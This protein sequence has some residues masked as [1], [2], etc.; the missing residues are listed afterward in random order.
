[1]QKEMYLL[2][3]VMIQLLN[4]GI[5]GS[6]CF[7][8]FIVSSRNGQCIQTLSDGQDSISSVCMDDTC[9]ITGYVLM[10]HFKYIRSVDGSIRTYDIRAGQLHQDNIKSIISTIFH[11]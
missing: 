1:M 9:I 2:L 3:Q 11:D 8:C 10:I 6:D 7:L 4:Y 5:L